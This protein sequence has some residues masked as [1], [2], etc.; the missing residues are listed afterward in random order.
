MDMC[1]HVGPKKMQEARTEQA[2]AQE[3]ANAAAA[4]R[5]IALAAQQALASDKTKL[6]RH[7]A[8][9]NARLQAP[10]P[11]SSPTKCVF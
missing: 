4:E 3:A 10:R 2:S 1:T 6:A 11:A 9:S 5:D 7:L 8:A